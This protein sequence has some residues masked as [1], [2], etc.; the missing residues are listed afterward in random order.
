[1]FSM[2]FLISTGHLEMILS[3]YLLLI[4]TVAVK[5]FYNPNNCTL[6]LLAVGNT[7][8]LNNLLNCIQIHIILVKILIMICL[9]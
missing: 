9:L 8:L 1:M 4:V 3:V 5:V 6:L 7:L 2:V